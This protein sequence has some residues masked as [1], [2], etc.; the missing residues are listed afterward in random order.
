MRKGVLTSGA[1][2]IVVSASLAARTDS[3]PVIIDSGWIIL[4][5][6]KEKPVFLPTLKAAITASQQR[7]HPNLVME[8]NPYCYMFSFTSMDIGLPFDV[9]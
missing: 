4:S 3:V 7:I 5:H 2:T 9:Y 1:V 8:S 6:M